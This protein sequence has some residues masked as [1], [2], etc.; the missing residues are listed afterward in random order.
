MIAPDLKVVGPTMG[1]KFSFCNS[2]LLRS[3]IKPVEMKSTMA[4][5]EIIPCFSLGTINLTVRYTIKLCL[6]PFSLYPQCVYGVLTKTHTLISAFRYGTFIC[7]L[8]NRFD[9]RSRRYDYLLFSNRHIAYMSLKRRKSSKQPT[10]QLY[11]TKRYTS[12]HPLHFHELK[13]QILEINGIGA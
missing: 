1:K 3:S 13:V 12:I 6:A 11:E 8:R 7:T 5:T 10:N 9:S 2:R 4:Y